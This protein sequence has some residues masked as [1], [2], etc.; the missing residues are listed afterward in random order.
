MLFGHRTSNGG[1][2]RYMH[3]MR[4]GQT[5]SLKGGDGR[6]YHYRIVRVGVTTPTFSNIAAMSTPY[7]PVTAQLI[8]CSKRDG[9]P[10]SLYYRLVVTG[11]LVSVTG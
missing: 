7:P 11:I 3:T 10:T 1:M 9:T 6:W 4:T 5:F 8:A 2:F